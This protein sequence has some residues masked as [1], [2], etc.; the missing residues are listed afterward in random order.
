MEAYKAADKMA[1]AVLVGR[2]HKLFYNKAYWLVKDKDTAKDIAQE[3]WTVIIKKTDSLKDSS[4]LSIG[5]TE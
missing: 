4:N 2:W 5:R 3:S 1:M